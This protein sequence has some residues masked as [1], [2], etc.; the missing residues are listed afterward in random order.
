MK[1]LLDTCVLSELVRKDASHSV[2]R[3]VERIPEDSLYLSVVTVGEIGKGVA[4]LEAGKRRGELERWLAEIRKNYADRILPIDADTA[5]I[6]G[7]IT[8]NAQRRGVILPAADGLIAATALQYNL[9][10]MT[11]NTRDFEAT[12]VL[13]ENPW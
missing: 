4:M 6:W 8:A 3:A 7:E 13:V 1:F 2:R 11:R 10:L 9:R 12:G 5:S